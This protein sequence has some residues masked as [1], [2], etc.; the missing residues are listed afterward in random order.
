M[1]LVLVLGKN[2]FSHICDDVVSLDVSQASGRSAN[3]R[4]L[5]S[6]YPHCYVKYFWSRNLEVNYWMIYV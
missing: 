6:F 1:G 3:A 5:E 4:L 2:Y